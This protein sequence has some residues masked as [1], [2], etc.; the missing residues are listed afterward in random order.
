[1]LNAS[2]VVDGA[3]GRDELIGQAVVDDDFASAV[4]ETREVRIVGADD[5]A[6]LLD[7]LCEEQLEARGGE[8]GEV[9]LRVLEEE[10]LEPLERDAEGPAS[11]RRTARAREGEEVRAARE[12]VPE[13]LSILSARALPDF[14]DHV[15]VGFGE[16]VV[17]DLCA[18]ER[19]RVVVA[20]RGIVDDAIGDS[21]EF[22]ACFDG[23][24]CGCV[25]LGARHEIFRV[26]HDNLR[27]ENGG[28]EAMPIDS[29]TAGDDAVVIVGV[30]LR[31]HQALAPTG[32]AAHKVGVTRGLAVEDLREC[33]AHDGHVVNAEIGIVADGLPVEAA[34]RVEGKAAA[35]AFMAGV[36]CA[37]GVTLG[38]GSAQAAG[39]AAGKSTAAVAAK[40]SVPVGDWQP[41]ENFDAVTGRRVGD[42]GGDATPTIRRID[43]RGID[44]RV[45]K[46]NFREVFAWADRLGVGVKWFW[47]S[48]RG[49]RK[50]DRGEE[51]GDDDE[52]FRFHG[53]GGG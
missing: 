16:S 29:R 52:E 1:M 36:R 3:F 14:A 43:D 32:R 24:G 22:V 47:R 5:G 20:A 11:Q 28:D 9:P 7:G 37:R 25:E 40:S 48:V 10:I 26:D 15:G 34:L 49:A 23:G 30:T 2:V 45:W 35:A 21:I 31:F 42:G 39:A 33:L 53:R 50:G 18:D 6:V 12:P 17:A 44:G 13:K 46:G 51:R 38:D 8:R 41:D 19:F 4:A 27:P